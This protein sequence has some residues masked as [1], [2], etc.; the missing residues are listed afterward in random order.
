M[1][2]E[3]IETNINV[4]EIESESLVHFKHVDKVRNL[5]KL[6]SSLDQSHKHA[7]NPMLSPLS[8]LDVL[9][10]I[11]KLL[12]HLFTYITVPIDFSR[13]CD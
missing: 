3:K 13:L 10:D 2:I 6:V 11:H 7:H 12:F 5:W 4:P 9:C 8:K 1:K